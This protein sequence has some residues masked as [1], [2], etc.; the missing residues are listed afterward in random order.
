[1]YMTKHP[2]TGMGMI[3]LGP[4]ETSS[5]GLG[6]PTSDYTGDPGSIDTSIPSSA[7]TSTTDLSSW[8]NS[9]W[10]GTPTVS[11]NPLDNTTIQSVVN[12]LQ[13]Q[14]NAINSPSSTTPG[15]AGASSAGLLNS[16]L[17]DANNIAKIVLTPGGSY[18]I[19]N[20]LTGAVTT[21]QGTGQPSALP[22]NLGSAFG[23]SLGSLSGILP[24]LLIGVAAFFVIGAMEKH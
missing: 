1:M 7:V 5:L 11:A 2:Y 6:D 20:P 24:I 13:D 12:D 22:L 4:S 23:T 10:G 9:V 21:Y 16:V 8:F 15:S 14:I 3:N 19:T 17:S 18:S